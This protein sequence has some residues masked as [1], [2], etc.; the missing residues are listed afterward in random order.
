MLRAVP[1]VHLRV[2]VPSRDATA[3]T[4]AIAREGLLHLVDLAHGRVPGTGPREGLAD[5]LAAFRDLARRL[6]QVSARLG[7]PPPDPSGR[8]ADAPVG[9]LAAERDAIEARL[10]P[11]A[12]A[13]DD[14]WRG[15]KDAEA[16][17]T[18]A[19]AALVRARTLAE[20]GVDPVRLARLRWAHVR[21]VAAG[22]EALRQVASLLAPLPFS[23]IP[24]PS[25]GEPALAAVA[26]IASG[27]ERLDRAAR[28]AGAEIIELPDGP[29]DPDALARDVA[30]AEAERAAREAELAGLRAA[31]GALVAELL[32]RA[33]LAA[34]LLQAQACF[35][36]AGRFLVISGWVPAQG[37][38]RMRDAIV[39][40]TGGRACVDIEEPEGMPE[41]AEGRLRVP[42]LHRNPLIFRPFQRLIG[43]YG[44]PSYQEVEPTAF[45]A[46]SFLL[47]FGLMFGDLGQGLVLCSAGWLLFRH[48]P[49]FLDYGILLM[50]A[51]AAAAVFGLLYGS[52]FGMEHLLPALWLR[53][54]HDLGTFM[55]FTIGVGVVLLT[56]GLVL[57]A[58]NTWRSGQ[59][60]GAIL[61]RRGVLGALVY[62]ISIALVARAIAP[63]PFTVPG[64][65]IAALAGAAALLLVARPVVTRVLE[66]G[67]VRRRAHVPVGPLWLR[68][69]EGSIELVDLVFT[70]FTNTLSFVRVAAFAAVHA[71]VFLA[72]FA[73]ADT[74][75]RTRFG[76]P[77]SVLTIVAGNVV[78]I[79]LE[80]LTVSVQV[81]R[82]EYYEFFNRFFKGGGDPYRPLTL[83]ADG[84]A[85]KG[86]RH[87]NDETARPDARA[88]AGARGAAGAG[89]AG[90]GG[91]GAAG[92]GVGD[93][94]RA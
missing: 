26:T 22:D 18:R 30:A 77:L 47:M 9:D 69:L 45:F 59:H 84:G 17:A 7:V 41:V 50:E 72:V 63:P 19:G 55:T 36:D 21:V 94:G 86:S 28:M 5:L 48:F 4:R 71:G 42:I 33:D 87:G 15:Q 90:H 78:V 65:L 39:A 35:A 73:I 93:A 24:L 58:V 10:R 57:S 40:A 67:P 38:P 76:G 92:A 75:A 29:L 3:A 51:G 14:A 68:A 52:V 53:P 83:R 70:S 60:A 49:R 1:M 54:I 37:A 25:A 74:V 27:R 46:L 44:T 16:R 80:G 81:L 89:G 8:L 12:R 85:E 56:G 62:W 91:A 88:G 32:P 20:A 43:L 2:Q 13:A 31:G 64:W 11:L 79:F 82:L 23:I 6:R 34:L 66:R 61:G